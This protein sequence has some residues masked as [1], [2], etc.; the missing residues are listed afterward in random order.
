MDFETAIALL[1]ADNA[2]PIKFNLL[3]GFCHDHEKVTRIFT[4]IINCSDDGEWEK[5]AF[6]KI[7]SIRI[8]DK[9]GIY[10]FSWKIPFV[11][12]EITEMHLVCYVGKAEDTSLRT[13]F[14]EYEKK[15]G[16]KPELLWREDPPDRAS[17][18]DKYLCLPN[19]DYIYCTVSESNK[20]KI[21]V[22]EDRLIEIYNPPVNIK[23]FKVKA[24]ISNS[25]KL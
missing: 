20:D 19:L 1:G 2:Q 17:R 16:Q 9:K 10:M 13:R 22:F 12:P 14:R 24:T 25:T 7:S 23:K 8:P 4:E 15:I 6:D 18:L 3:P 11:Y 5:L 21:Q